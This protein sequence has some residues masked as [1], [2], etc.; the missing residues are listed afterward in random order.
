VTWKAYAPLGALSLAAIVGT[1]LLQ[2]AE[3]P[4]FLPYFGSLNP[5]LTVATAAVL[6][7]GSLVYLQSR[8]WF[9]ISGAHPGSRNL[10]IGACAAVGFALPVIA[11]DFFGAFPRDINV[12]A[13]QSFVFYPVIALV[14]E[15]AFHAAPLA[16]LLLL[17]SPLA[18][19]LG[20]QRT[21]WSCAGLVAFIEPILQTIW[22]SPDTP[23]W[24]TAYVALHVFAI[25]LAILYFFGRFDFLTAYGF[26]VLYYLAWH[27]GWGAARL[28]L[29]FGG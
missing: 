23:A 3:S 27:I 24:A 14:A 21:R 17:A 13:P 11:I 28:P 25:N 4:A 26:R 29:L 18:T 5:I 8:G 19:R 1:G 20:R 9:A 12:S 22:A 6:V 7:S 10:L 15:T 2:L 16:I